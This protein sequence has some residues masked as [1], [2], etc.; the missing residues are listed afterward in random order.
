MSIIMMAG[1]DLSILVNDANECLSWI[2]CLLNILAVFYL[3]FCAWFRVTKF[4]KII[5]YI[6]SGVLV[7]GTVTVIALHACLF[8]ILSGVFTALVLMAM[9]AAIFSD[10]SF[11]GNE[12]IQ[13][14]K[15][16]GSYVIHKT[17]DNKYAFL[18][19]NDKK[20]VLSKSYFK[21][22]TIEAA[23]NAANQCKE[24]GKLA[25]V[26]NKTNNWVEIVNH[27]KF[28]VD[29]SDNKFSF[30]LY[31]N[32]K[33][34]IVVSE[35]FENK[36]QM[37]KKLQEVLLA[38]KSEKLYLAKEEVLAGNIFKEEKEAIKE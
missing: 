22:E 21:Y 17:D 20:V 24:S 2:I 34:P 19:Y 38:I 6:W 10:G 8:T 15:A 33:T 9:F 32:G 18:I 31:L 3:V 13:N 7:V 12:S 30:G 23:K 29:S 11:A 4:V 37:E 25:P 14:L 26:E 28:V 27:P 5:G 36:D 16:I 35:S 1:L